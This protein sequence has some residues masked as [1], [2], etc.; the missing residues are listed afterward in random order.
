MTDKTG[1]RPNSREEAGDAR[2]TDAQDHAVT[3]EE[4][5]DEGL[6]DSMDASD[7]PA[8]TTPGDDGHPVPSS[9]FH[10]DD[11]D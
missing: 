11:E 8:A 1:I 9:G 2:P 10:E 7:P 5:L 4:K 3:R 6:K